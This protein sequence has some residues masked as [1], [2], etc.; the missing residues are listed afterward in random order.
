MLRLIT[1]HFTPSMPSTDERAAPR[2]SRLKHEM[3]TLAIGCV[4]AVGI[5]LALYLV[6]PAEM[7][8]RI[9]AAFLGF[10]QPTNAPHGH[11]PLPR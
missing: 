9:V 10:D 3:L 8:D 5:T 2:T 11:P 1:Y 4:A 6:A 7:R